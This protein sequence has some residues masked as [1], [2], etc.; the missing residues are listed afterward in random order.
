[1][2]PAWLDKAMIYGPLGV[3]ALLVVWGIREAWF[4]IWQA[5]FRSP[6]VGENGRHDEGGYVIR[7]FSKAVESIDANNKATEALSEATVRIE[8]KLDK[9]LG[10]AACRNFAPPDGG[11]SIHGR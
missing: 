2:D 7:F 10:G 11:S 5:M 9:V 6:S 1:M 8:G 3:F 4:A